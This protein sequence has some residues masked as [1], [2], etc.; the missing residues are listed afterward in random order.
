[1]TYNSNS[2]CSSA[3]RFRGE[4]ADGDGG[5]D[6]HDTRRLGSS[7]QQHRCYTAVSPYSCTSPA[8]TAADASAR[9]SS[10]PSCRFAQRINTVGRR[11]RTRRRSR[12]GRIVSAAADLISTVQRKGR[13][14]FALS[15]LLLIFVSTSSSSGGIFIAWNG[16]DKINDA[17]TTAAIIA[18]NL[19]SRG[20]RRG[21]S[22]R[23]HGDRN[24]QRGSPRGYNS[25][26]RRHSSSSSRR[27]RG[28]YTS[29]LSDV[30]FCLAMA[31]GWT[32]WMLSSFIKSDWSKYQKNSVLVHGNV[33][34]VTVEDDSLG[35]GIPTY[36]AII[37]YMV[38]KAH[39]YG[40]SPSPH[41][42]NRGVIDTT[43]VCPDIKHG[44][45]YFENEEDQTI[46][47]RKQV[48][49]AP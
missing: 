17:A 47:I 20:H 25:V 40:G 36:K 7:Q 18:R 10:A 43:S 38:P 2:S 48:R 39:S 28:S 45:G 12:D 11:Q 13:Y 14:A 49:F 15:I 41:D 4:G 32:V 31:L 37:D 9:L 22:R 29:H 19:Q 46:Q 16:P 44:G 26:R 42:Y 5:D 6:Q 33:L 21:S 23:G 34:Q 35:T 27:R 3:R 30:A 24:R 1:M 8:A